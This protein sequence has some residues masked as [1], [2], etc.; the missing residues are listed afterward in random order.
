MVGT[1]DR[2][3]IAGFIPEQGADRHA[4]DF[5]VTIAVNRQRMWV[6]LDDGEHIVGE[7]DAAVREP[8]KPGHAIR[9]GAGGVSFH[10][11]VSRHDGG[12]EISNYSGRLAEEGVMA[13]L[14]RD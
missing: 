5:I 10:D 2:F 11:G 8:D 12:D 1:L 14:P 3:A 7:K 4:D 9:V 6:R 13:V